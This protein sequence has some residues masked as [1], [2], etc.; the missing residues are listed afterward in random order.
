MRFNFNSCNS[1]SVV[2]NKVYINGK[3]V[4][5]IEDCKEKNIE[6]VINGNVTGDVEVQG[7]LE[8]GDIGG[9]VDIQGNMTC[10]TIKG[11]VDCQGNIKV[12]K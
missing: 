5:E 6:V 2:N 8:C 7:R 11:D 12:V 3:L 4:S 10:Q 9:N 1:I